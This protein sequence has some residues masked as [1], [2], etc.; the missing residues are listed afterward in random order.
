[1]S[2]NWRSGAIRLWIVVSI[3]WVAITAFALE[4]HES[5]YTYW[6]FSDEKILQGKSAKEN[7]LATQENKPTDMFI[8]LKNMETRDIS[9]DEMRDRLSKFR[10]TLDP[11]QYYAV[12]NEMFR[13]R[14]IAE[15]QIKIFS[16]SAITVP[17]VIFALG[18]LVFWIVRGFKR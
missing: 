15:N 3:L 9:Y 13:R 7:G 11:I 4:V 8:S 12:I 14:E 6:I 16:F 1:M 10:E 18:S 17:A 2:V 5:I